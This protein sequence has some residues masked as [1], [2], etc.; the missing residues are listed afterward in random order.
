MSKLFKL[1]KKVWG[2]YRQVMAAKGLL[3][4]LGWW[5]VIA[6]IFATA[7]GRVVYAWNNVPVPVR[8]LAALATFTLT[9]LI[10]ILAVLIKKALAIPDSE[11]TQVTPAAT[12]MP[13]DRPEVV[14]EYS[15]EDRN[16]FQTMPEALARN[17]NKPVIVRNVSLTRT[18]YN[19]RVLPLTVNTEHGTFSPA[20][21][22]FLA[23]QASAN[24]NVKIPESSPLF[25]HNLPHFLRRAYTDS[26]VDELMSD[27][28]F[29][30]SAEYDDGTGMSVRTT[31]QLLYRPWKDRTRIG[32]I[33]HELIAKAAKA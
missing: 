9:C 29:T 18:A 25:S 30:I 10:F 28:I 1:L 24:V 21:I 19:I 3:D 4:L 8:I 26:S 7:L 12:Q 33:E 14:F 15:Y 6:A 11:M 2:L 23:P 20:I 31:A 16:A 5:A 27:R 32:A 17:P 13:A 22:P